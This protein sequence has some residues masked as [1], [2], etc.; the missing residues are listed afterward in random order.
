MRCELHPENANVTEHMWAVNLFR[1]T[2]SVAYEANLAAFDQHFSLTRSTSYVILKI[3]VNNSLGCVDTYSALSDTFFVSMFDLKQLRCFVAVGEEL[4]FGRAARRM[5]MTQPPLSRQIQLLEHDLDMQL[6]YRTRRSVTLTP[7]GTVFLQEAK[8]LL[9]H[10][11]TAAST[12]QRVARGESGLL[13]VGFTAGASHD[14]LPRLLTRTNRSLVGVNL[15]LQEMVSE[16]Q[17]EAL[18]NGQIDIGL[19]RSPLNRNVYEAV[20]V[21]RESLLL[22]IPREHPLAGGKMP[23]LHDLEGEPFIMYCPHQGSYFHALVEGLFRTASIPTKYVQQL[24]QIHSILALVNAGHGIAL[25]P[26]SARILHFNETVLRR[27]KLPPIYAEIFLAWKRDN[28]N[29]AIP[30]FRELVMKH[31][32]LPTSHAAMKA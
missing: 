15:V 17:T 16:Y 4:H 26:E 10:A 29:P 3:R 25:V 13:T 1:S 14:F 6:L 30:R 2:I 8:R 18:K 9:F 12:A 19:L 22:A 27:I 11:E 31:F 5:H 28:T 24:S 7:A 20:C 32:A 21:A 23:A